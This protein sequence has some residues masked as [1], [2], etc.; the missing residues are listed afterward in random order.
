MGYQ[1][2]HKRIRE[3]YSP[4]M[5]A[6]EVRHREYVRDQPCFGCGS[7]ADHAHHTLLKWPGKRWRRDHRC[8][9]PV[10][11]GCH[12]VIHDHLGDEEVWL[13]LFGIEPSDAIAEMERL[14]AESELIE[15]M[16]GRA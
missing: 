11:L 6:A 2:N 7:I 12:A 13:D 8:L 3:H 5:T 1:V 14:W 9:L 16:G 10:C 4:T 15:R